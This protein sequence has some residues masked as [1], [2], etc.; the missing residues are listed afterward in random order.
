MIGWICI[1]FRG[2]LFVSKDVQKVGRHLA[3]ASIYQLILNMGYRKRS[4]IQWILS[5]SYKACYP[6]RSC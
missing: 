3:G 2:D 1:K 6:N 4:V 5:D